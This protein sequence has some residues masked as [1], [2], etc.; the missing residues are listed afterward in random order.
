MRFVPATAR[1][2]PQ[3]S[4]VAFGGLYYAQTNPKGAIHFG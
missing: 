2:I 4:T 3:K 1:F